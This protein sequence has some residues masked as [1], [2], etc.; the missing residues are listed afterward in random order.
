MVHG[1]VAVPQGSLPS[2]S[3]AGSVGSTSTHKGRGKMSRALSWQSYQAAEAAAAEEAA[4]AARNAHLGNNMEV[5]EAEKEFLDALFAAQNQR[6][7][8]TFGMK[9]D[10]AYTWSGSSGITHR[11]GAVGAGS[12][13]GA[14]TGTDASAKHPDGADGRRKELPPEPLLPDLYDRSSLGQSVDVA[15]KLPVKRP[16]PTLRPHLPHIRTATVPTP[17]VPLSHSSTYH[18]L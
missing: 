17:P 16:E 11:S 12:T 6:R 2:T 9:T 8:Q 14:G 10:S 4:E 18:P 15:R 1:L 7:K 13:A 3:D 5:I